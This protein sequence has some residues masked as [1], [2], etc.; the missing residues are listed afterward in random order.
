M[1]MFAL[2]AGMVAL[3][4]VGGAQ[5]APVPVQAGATA[6]DD[7]L[8]QGAGHGMRH[9]GGC[10]TRHGHGKRGGRHGGM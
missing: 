4:T 2:A 10:G 7:S 8:I 3:V 6:S 1:K 9:G 5:A